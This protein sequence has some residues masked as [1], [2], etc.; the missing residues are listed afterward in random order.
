MFSSS[1]SLVVVALCRL[2]PVPASFSDI[3]I[4]LFVVVASLS[5]LSPETALVSFSTEFGWW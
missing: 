4:L 3:G 1:E 5:S 2:F